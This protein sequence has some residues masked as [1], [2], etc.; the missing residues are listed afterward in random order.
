[1]FDHFSFNK[2]SF[3]T[4][5]ESVSSDFPI[6]AYGNA[7]ADFLITY[8]L[9]IALDGNAGDIAGISSEYGDRKS[10]V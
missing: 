7:I 9:E 8:N 2:D 1:M 3:D 6:L 10:V 4:Q 5:E